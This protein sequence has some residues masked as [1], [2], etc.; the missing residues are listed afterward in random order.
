ME[1]PRMHFLE[2]G[3]ICCLSLHFGKRIRKMCFREEE[4]KGSRR[5]RRGVGRDLYTHY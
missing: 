4:K 1:V 2:M 3:N 5:R